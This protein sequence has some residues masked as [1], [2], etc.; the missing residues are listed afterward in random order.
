MRKLI[1]E[2]EDLSNLVVIKK[3]V[4]SSFFIVLNANDFFGYACSDS[5]QIDTDDL[6]WIIPIVKKYPKYGLDACMAYIAK[7]LP[8]KPYLT[9]EFKKAYLELEKLKPEVLSEY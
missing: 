5:V 1:I 9:E 4:D 8:I 3:I 7:Q 2:K 6:H